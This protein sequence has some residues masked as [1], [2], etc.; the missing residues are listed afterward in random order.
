MILLLKH[1]QLHFCPYRMVSPTF[2]NY[3]G[4]FFRQFQNNILLLGLSVTHR[5]PEY[6]VVS[7]P[8]QASVLPWTIFY[9]QEQI[10]N[11]DSV[12]EDSHSSFPDVS[13]PGEERCC[14]WVIFGTSTEINSN[15][16]HV[17][18]SCA[19]AFKIIFLGSPLRAVIWLWSYCL[20]PIT[21]CIGEHKTWCSFLVYRWSIHL[22]FLIHH[23]HLSRFSHIL[24]ILVGDIV[25]CWDNMSAEGRVHDIWAWGIVVEVG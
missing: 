13:E 4:L 3:I 18:Y 6:L 8:Y 25:R 11:H 2:L 21:V 7:L 12:W 19:N 24:V 17:I 20:H 22:Y 15:Q 14:C 5:Q 10:T 1:L 9:S 23:H 16:I